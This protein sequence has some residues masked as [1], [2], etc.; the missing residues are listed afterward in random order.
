MQTQ[1]ETSAPSRPH[2]A[3]RLRDHGQLLPLCGVVY[4]VLLVAAAV[5]FPAAP[6]G[7]VSPAMN[8]GWLASHTG[9]VI[10]QSYVR[11][12]AAAA[13]VLLGVAIAGRI[14]SRIVDAPALGWAAGGGGATAG[15]LMAMGQACALASALF[16]RDGGTADEV[17]LLGALQ[18]ALLDVSALPAIFLFAATGLAGVRGLLPRWLSVLSLV[19]VP[20]GIVDAL[21]YDGGPLGPIDVVGLVYFLAWAMLV[22]ANLSRSRRPEHA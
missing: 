9:A 1:E 12:S 19:G 22:G 17:R 7:D 2:S 4:T 20:F 3:Q 18:E 21:S 8:P 13:F 5:A 16:V 11:A 10:A 15:S 6:G 14:R